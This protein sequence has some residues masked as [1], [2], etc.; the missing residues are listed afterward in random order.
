MP[1]HCPSAAVPSEVPRAGKQLQATWVMQRE[2]RHP[3][4]T[5]AQAIAFA[6]LLLFYSEA[7][8]TSFNIGFLLLPCWGSRAVLDQLPETA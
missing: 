1:V 6:L 8:G 5:W 3:T 7:Q 4:N 2:L